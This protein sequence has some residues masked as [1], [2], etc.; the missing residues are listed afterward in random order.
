MGPKK[1]SN[2]AI[3][4]IYVDYN[5][6]TLELDILTPISPLIVSILKIF[7]QKYSKEAKTLVPKKQKTKVCKC[8]RED[9]TILRHVNWGLCIR[10]SI[11]RNGT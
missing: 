1:Y 3:I 9:K 8:Q 2:L 4:Q 10:K 5:K 6:F 7:E 11:K